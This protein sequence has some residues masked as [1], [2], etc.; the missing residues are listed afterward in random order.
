MK[1]GW[2]HLQLQMG[3]LMPNIPQIV[4]PKEYHRREPLRMDPCP[5]RRFVLMIKTKYMQDEA[6]NSPSAGSSGGKQLHR[7]GS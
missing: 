1:Q 4:G 3:E 5:E 2:V 6:S 7:N